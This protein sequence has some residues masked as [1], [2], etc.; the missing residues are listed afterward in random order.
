MGDTDN[1][2]DTIVPRSDQLN[3]DDLLTG[4][5]TVTIQAVKRGTEEQPV[6]VHIDGGHQ[7]YKPCL[8]MR[9]VMIA[10]WG[11]RGADWVGKKLTLY[12]DPRVKL[13]GAEVGG[14]RISH[15]SLPKP[16]TVKLT[17]SRGRRVDYTVQPLPASA[18][19]TRADA[20]REWLAQKGLSEQAASEHIGR[21]LDDAKPEDFAA[22][23]AWAKEQK[24]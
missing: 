3:Y 19:R 15:M 14:I 9:R 8:T 11:E 7:P 18:T 6:V 1:L 21:C 12:G 4:P 24:A 20:C 22:I 17:I 5:I 13:K 16:L 10:A 23:N 2:R